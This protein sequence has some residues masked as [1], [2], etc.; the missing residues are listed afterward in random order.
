MARS[1]TADSLEFGRDQNTEHAGHPAPRG[2]VL[3]S[4]TRAAAGLYTD[5]SG[6]IAVRFLREQGFCTPDA[7]V[8]ADKD[9]S[10]VI[11]EIFASSDRPDVILTS[12]GTGISPDDQVIESIQAHLDR[13]LP[14]IV[15]AFWSKGLEKTPTATLSRALAGTV[16]QTFVMAMPGSPGGVRDGVKVLEDVLVHA[17]N[18][19]KG[20]QVTNHDKHHS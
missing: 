5:E 7:R 13:E 10:V 9:I 20:R 11:A 1:D 3:V 14:G 12:G 16:G 8:V 19:L 15:H 4:S 2:L 17:I 18:I 6:P